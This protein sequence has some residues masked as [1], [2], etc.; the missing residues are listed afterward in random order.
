MHYNYQNAN[1]NL[2][3]AVWKKGSIIKDFDPNIWRYDTC[4][5]VIKFSDHGNTDSK[6]GWEI[7]HIKPASLGGS[8]DLT[9]LQPL[10][11]KTNRSKGDTFPWACSM[12]A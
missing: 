10:F 3:N 11:W 1:Q 9:N 8:D 5:N 7:D 4:S 6:Y 2:I 12:A